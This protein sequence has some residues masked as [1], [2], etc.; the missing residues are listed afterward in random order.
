[1][2]ASSKSLTKTR[3]Y[4]NK[5]IIKQSNNE[6]SLYSSPIF[7]NLDKM[8]QKS[9]QKNVGSYVQFNCDSI[10]F[11]KPDIMWLKNNQVLSEEDYGITR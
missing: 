4:S 7:I 1:M 3:L 8:E 6:N 5:N 9:Y 11:P 10:G 2:N